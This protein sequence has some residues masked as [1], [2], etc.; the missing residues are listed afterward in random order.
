MAD[1][2][3]TRTRASRDRYVKNKTIWY[4]QQIWKA[5]RGKNTQSTID[6]LARLAEFKVLYG[7]TDERPG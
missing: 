6:W 3:V 5:S 2:V 4:K 1:D 7:I